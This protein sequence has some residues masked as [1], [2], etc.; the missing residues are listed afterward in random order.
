MCHN[1]RIHHWAV[2]FKEVTPGFWSGCDR[3][4]LCSE[5]AFHFQRWRKLPILALLCP[6][7]RLEFG[8]DDLVVTGAR[9][10]RVLQ[11]FL[12]AAQWSYVTCKRSK[13]WFSSR[14]WFD[15]ECSAG[16]LAKGLL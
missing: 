9:L 3:R 4:N 10:P 11:I 13:E 8:C 16:L 7:I 12:L 15:F 1:K 5:R 6:K 14:L 2:P